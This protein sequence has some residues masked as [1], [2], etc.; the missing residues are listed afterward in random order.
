MGE[1][2]RPTEGSGQESLDPGHFSSWGST[3][4]SSVPW[5]GLHVRLP[6][7]PAGS[8]GVQRKWASPPASLCSCSL[9]RRC[10]GQAHSE[11]AG[12][13]PQASPASQAELPDFHS[14]SLH[15]PQCSFWWKQRQLAQTNSPSN[16]VLD[17][18]LPQ[19]SLK[20]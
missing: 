13:L 17:T 18:L 2:D 5:R 10:R 1:T 14:L 9:G 8:P 15:V 3:A 20:E 11:P 4:T 19:F 7:S 12:R 16:P 6:S